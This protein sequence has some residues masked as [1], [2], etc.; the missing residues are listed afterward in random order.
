M[1]SCT[2]SPSSFRALAQLISSLLKFILL[3]IAQLVV[4]Y[5]QQLGNYVL[6]FL[7]KVSSTILMVFAQ[8]TTARKAH[9]RWKLMMAVNFRCMY[10]ISAHSF[11][12]SYC[13][14]GFKVRAGDESAV[15][16]R[17][18]EGYYE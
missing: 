1:L 6:F 3:L 9:Q 17:L 14:V 2:G 18:S 16:W 13:L 11:V 8:L 12:R 5:L 7:E 10:G 4:E 15:E